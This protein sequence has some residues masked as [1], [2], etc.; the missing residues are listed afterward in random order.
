MEVTKLTTYTLSNTL[1]FPDIIYIVILYIYYIYSDIIYI[2][3]IL[4][5]I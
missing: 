3:Y 1:R 2:I 5:Y 4:I